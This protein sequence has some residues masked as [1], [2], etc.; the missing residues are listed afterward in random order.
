MAAASAR[1][2]KCA[3]TLL[4]RDSCDDERATGTQQ[5]M[6]SVCGDDGD[7]WCLPAA[8][9]LRAAHTGIARADG[10]ASSAVQRSAVH[11]V[12]GRCSQHNSS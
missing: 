9:A 3:K 2:M 8:D 10:G 11:V 4:T 7:R 5:V 12:R 1:M 6:R